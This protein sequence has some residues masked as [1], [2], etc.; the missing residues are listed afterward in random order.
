MTGARPSPGSSRTGIA[1]LAGRVPT[2]HL[3]VAE[4][5]YQRD[6]PSRETEPRANTLPPSPTTGGPQVIDPNR[7]E[8]AARWARVV[9]PDP[10]AELIAREIAAYL[11]LGFRFGGGAL[12]AQVAEHVLETGLTSESSPSQTST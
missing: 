7:L 4:H 1:P 9:F 10:I 2:A 6:R 8:A 3:A 11:D 5:P 12:V